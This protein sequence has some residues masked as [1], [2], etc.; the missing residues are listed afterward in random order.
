MTTIRD[1]KG[2]EILPGD[3]LKSPHYI[4]GLGRKHYLYH[5]AA[6]R[7]DGTLEARPVETLAR[8]MAGGTFLLTESNAVISEIIY[9]FDPK[10][11]VDFRDRPRVMSK[12]R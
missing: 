6:L 3:L 7:W 10:T 4:D 1:K 9:G 8:E 11:L 12:G 2:R 5:V